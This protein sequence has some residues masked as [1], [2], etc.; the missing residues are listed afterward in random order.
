MSEQTAQYWKILTNDFRPPLRGGA[1]LCDGK[2]WPVELPTVPLDRSDSE[3]GVKGGWHFC[4]TI[5]SAFKIAGLWR[6]GRPNAVVL[7]DPHGDIIERADKLRASSL[8]LLRI[9]TDDEIRAALVAFSAPFGAHQAVMAIEQW[10]W[11]QALSRPLRNRDN[12]I[13]GVTIALRARSLDWTIKEFNSERAA[14]DARA[15][16]EPFDAWA[17]WAGWTDWSAGAATA[18]DAW[19]ASPWAALT[20]QY[21]ARNGWISQSSDCLTIGIRDAYMNG[22]TLAIPTGPKELGIVLEPWVAED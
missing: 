11:W 21:A 16:W 7:V 8:T 2:E 4:H 15:V 22:L 10:L 1:P 5:E 3:C 9:A 6:T 20:V 19:Y 17:A 14:W 12:V 13:E 18:R